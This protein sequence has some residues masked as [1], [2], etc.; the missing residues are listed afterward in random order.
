LWGESF[1]TAWGWYDFYN[2]VLFKPGV[3]VKAFEEKLPAYIYKHSGR[4]DESKSVKFVMQPLPEIHLYSD[5][6]Q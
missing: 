4:E 5:L 6:I 3:D 2:Y 1:E